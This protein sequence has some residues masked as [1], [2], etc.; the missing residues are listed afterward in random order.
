MSPM[1]LRTTHNRYNQLCVYSNENKCSS[2]FI[3]K[4]FNREN[5]TPYKSHSL[6]FIICELLAKA[7]I[8]HSMLSM[9]L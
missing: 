6:M 2:W 8:A 7:R 3:F 5:Y 9:T 1:Y 4:S